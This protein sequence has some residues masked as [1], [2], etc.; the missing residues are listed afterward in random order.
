MEQ[1]ITLLEGDALEIMKGMPDD[2]GFDFVLLACVLTCLSISGHTS[3][4][5]SNTPGSAMINASGF[6]SFNSLKYSRTPSRSYLEQM[7]FILEE[8]HLDFV[9]R[10]RTFPKKI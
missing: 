4:A 5:I 3:F 6:I 8:K 7:Q 1:K 10:Q 2:A 9:Q